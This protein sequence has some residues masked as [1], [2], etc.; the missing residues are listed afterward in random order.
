MQSPLANALKVLVAEDDR[1]TQRLLLA[2]LTQHPALVAHGF[3]VVVAPDGQAAVM[4]FEEVHPDLVIVDLFMPRLD[5]FS[6]CRAIRESPHGGKVPIIVTSAV[7]KQPEVLE[8]LRAD[9]GVVFVEKPIL[10][11]VLARAVQSVL[12]GGS[13]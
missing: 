5:G 13:P 6:V 12:L 1:M 10:P 8:Q 9:F 4:R 2:T 3:Q 7:W 11:D